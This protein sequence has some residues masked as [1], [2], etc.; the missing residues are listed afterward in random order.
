MACY[1]TIVHELV[2][3]KMLIDDNIMMAHVCWT[4][5]IYLHWIHYYFRIATLFI[6]SIYFDDVFFCFLIVDI[7]IYFL[8]SCWYC[9]LHL[10]AYPSFCCCPS[11]VICILLVDV[12]W[13]IWLKSG[14]CVIMLH[15]GWDKVVLQHDSCENS[16]GVRVGDRSSLLLFGLAYLF[17]CSWSI[18]WSCMDLPR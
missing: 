12:N 4:I 16:S 5:A 1:V 10:C 9:F 13:A 11:N 2:H 14:I 3:N 6:L 18:L 17:S 7:E 15:S 8:Q